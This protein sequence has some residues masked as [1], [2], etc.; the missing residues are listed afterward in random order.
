[1]TNTT[2]Y[3]KTAWLGN[4]PAHWQVLRIKNI[5][6]E[7]EDRS[8]S[9]SED[10]LSVSHYTG[11][12]LK[13]D[14]LNSEDDFISNAETLEGYK[15]VAQGDL[16]INI[17]L[18]WN[19]SLG[20]SPYDGITSPAY[21]VYRAKENNN[22]EYFGYLFASNL[23]KTEFRKKS[24]GI[25]DS[26]LRLYSDKFFSIFSVVPPIAEQN[27]IV[28]YIKTQSQK[29]N[30]F[31]SKKQQFITLLKEQRQSVINEAVTKGIDKKVKLKDSGIKWLGN[32]PEH[33]EVRRLKNC[34]NGKLRYGANESGYEYNPSWYRY[35]R[36]TDF[37]KEGFLDEHNKLSLPIEIGV[38]YELA[39]GDILFARSG[40]TVGKTFQFRFVSDEEKYCYAGYLIKA[41]P[42]ESI[43]L[44]NFLMEYTNS[45]VFENW[46]NS[47]F[48]KA[49]IEN[50]GADKY[51]VLKVP[52]PPITEQKQILDFIKTETATIDTAIA[53]TVREIELIKEYK[54]AMI[55]E[56]VLGKIHLSH[57]ATTEQPKVKKETTWEFKE[58]VL[59]AILTD[60]FSSAQYPIGRKRY[61]KF[62]YLFHRYTDNK[63][64]GYL[65][66]A[67]GP[68][69]P[70]T[71]YAGP[72]KIAL[73]NKYVIEVQNGK[74]SGFVAGSK[75]DDAR[76]YFKNYWE[77]DSLN[78][79]EKLKYKKNDELE[80]I[81]TI[82]KAIA[83][84]NEKEE[85]INL[86]N[87]KKVITETKDWKAKLEREIFSDDNIVRAINELKTFFN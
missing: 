30:H 74:L 56:A 85:A 35:I 7:I 34:I 10:L 73:Q 84:L 36:I 38:E 24:T 61:T 39:D 54:E 81:A 69:N 8:T 14:S 75:I 18:A 59:I 87:I 78:W 6:S 64:E 17:M 43:I 26:R 66:K 53:K 48:N 57:S 42:N 63:T 58:A 9:G 47:I 55:A 12:T 79:L 22:P 72:E 49:T 1:M 68:Y 25:I 4:Y 15:K 65:K 40:A 62:S 32:I 13:R 67:A 29:I 19:G 86:T 70:K 60:K 51:C 31:I 45:I 71:K 83:E 80:L 5:F 44:S 41:S 3:N 52:V 2:T 37:T 21:C 27:Q 76:N 82:D 28:E 50:I 23:L 20:I 16:V 77:A 33:W 11:V 46:K